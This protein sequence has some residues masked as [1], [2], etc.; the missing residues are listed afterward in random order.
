MNL[1]HVKAGK[2]LFRMLLIGFLSISSSLIFAQ[3]QQVNLSG[4]DLTLKAAFKQIE[5]QTKL[6]I[7]YNVQ[8]VNDSRPN[9]MSSIAVILR[10]GSTCCTGMVR[11]RAITLA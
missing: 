9:W 10:I 6:F 11:R 2:T 8:D 5:Q 3:H 7:D 4:S 1:I